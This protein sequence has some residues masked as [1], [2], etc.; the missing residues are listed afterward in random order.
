VSDS[1]HSPRLASD[2][3]HSPRLASDAD[4]SPRLASDADHS[5]PPASDADQ[6]PRPA[7]LAA[8]LRALGRTAAQHAGFTQALAAQLGIGQTD[9]ECLALLQDLGPTTAGQLAEVLGLTTG[10]I[11]GVVDR[12]AGAGFV[13]RES[14]PADRRRVIVEPIAERTVDLER[15]YAPVLEAAHRS[16]TTY[17]DA[18]LRLLLDFLGRASN[19]LL[20][21][22]QRLKAE[23]AELAAAGLFAQFSAP[24][25]EVRSGCLEF[26]SGASGVRI[27]AADAVLPRWERS[28]GTFPGNVPSGG[29]EVAG[30][31]YHA[32]FEGAQ[33][34]VRVLAGNV[35]I[36][37]KRMGPFEW[38]GSRHAGSV[39]LNPS[40]PWSIALRGGA[41]DVSLDGRQLQLRDIVV[42][43]GASKLLVLLPPPRG[44]VQVSI[45]GGL[46]RV[47]IKRPAGVPTQLKLQ[48][49]ANR[50]EVDG[51]RFGVVGG[52]LR[53]ASPD[54]DMA[55][56]RYAIEVRG[57][58]SRL[59][60]EE[61][62]EV[63]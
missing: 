18:D 60:L 36:R 55:R 8:V 27:Q 62:Q 5:P 51:Q 9:L 4:H 24:L 13:V 32:T 1:D 46:S 44:T 54:W 30:W 48:G 50:L 38:S 19:V 12:L 59:S 39:A 31:L 2:A 63:F 53:L 17:T 35:V 11:T 43:G 23:S 14:D 47:E 7:E 21:S 22:T 45:G 61:I 56:D 49:G 6:S 25:G 57:G 28:Q 33:P 20:Q 15:A 52:H 58:A 29:R 10:A 26:A 40:I 16:L 3:D 41:S 34:A 37:Y 42:D